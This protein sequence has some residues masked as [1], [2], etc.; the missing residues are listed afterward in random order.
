MNKV[1]KT[2]E[3]DKIKE[4]PDDKKE[5]NNVSLDE[6]MNKY[7][8]DEESY[9][10]LD[11][12]EDYKDEQEPEGNN[13][14]KNT[15]NDEEDL[16][17][18][19]VIS[20]IKDFDNNVFKYE[21]L[22][23]QDNYIIDEIKS[24]NAQKNY[25]MNSLQE[26]FLKVLQQFSFEE[27]NQCLFYSEVFIYLLKKTFFML[28]N[29]GPNDELINIFNI[30]QRFAAQIISK[31]NK[32]LN[33]KNKLSISEEDINSLCSITL[34]QIDF[35]IELYYIFITIR[36]LPQPDEFIDNSLEYLIKLY[37]LKNGTNKNLNEIDIVYI[38]KYIETIHQSIKNR[39]KL[40]ICLSLEQYK[41]IYTLG[42]LLL[43]DHRQLNIYYF[44][45]EMLCDIIELVD[46]N[47]YI[48][49]FLTEYLLCFNC[50]IEEYNLV[51]EKFKNYKFSKNIYSSYLNYFG[52]Y[53]LINSEDISLL[54]YF[55]MKV[56]CYLYLKNINYFTKF[57]E[58]ILQKIY[59]HNNQSFLL[60][61]LFIFKDFT[62]MKYDIEFSI[63][64]NIITHIYLSIASL[65]SSSDTNLVC[66]KFLVI[67]LKFFMNDLLKDLKSLRNSYLCFGKQN[68]ELKNILHINDTHETNKKKIKNKKNK[69]KDKKNNNDLDIE[70]EPK[71][72]IKCNCFSCCFSS[73][74]K[75]KSFKCGKCDINTNLRLQLI[76]PNKDDDL[77][78]C[79][80]CNINDYFKSFSNIFENEDKLELVKT[81]D[82]IFAQYSKYSKSFK[83]KENKKKKNDSNDDDEKM[84]DILTKTE[85]ENLNKDDNNFNKDNELFDKCVFY[86]EMMYKK[87]FLFLKLNLLNF[88]YISNQIQTQEKNENIYLS[89][90]VFLRSLL[91]EDK[92]KDKNYISFI[93]NLEQFFKVQKE[94]VFNLH[95]D[96]NIDEKTIQYF[97][98]FH[99]Y[100]NFL[101]NGHWKILEILI[102]D[103]S[104]FWQI[105]YQCMKILEKFI[106]ID[107]EAN[108]FQNLSVSIVGPLL[109]D[110]SLNI[111]EYSFELLFKL[112]QKKKIK[113]TD[114]IYILY[115]NINES[116][117][118]IRKRAI[119]ALS[120]LVFYEKER[121]SLK[122]IILIFLNKIYDNS[123]SDK[124]KSI[125]YDFF[126]QLFK[127]N[128]S[129][130]NEL[131][132]YF[133]NIIIELFSGSEEISGNYSNYLSTQL[134]LLFEK[135]YD[136]INTYD[137][138]IDYLMQN[139]IINKD[140]SNN[141][142]NNEN[143]EN[144]NEELSLTQRMEFIHALNFVQILTK[145]YKK[146]ISIYIEYFCS[147]LEYNGD[148]VLHNNRIIQLSCMII[149]NYFEEKKSGDND[150]SNIIEDEDT[151]TIKY[152]T[153]CK[154]ENL[155]LNIIMN[156]APVITFSALETYFKMIKNGVID[157]DKIEKFALM[158]FTFLKKLKEDEKKILNTQENIISKSL[159]I[160]SYI[161]YSLNDSEILNTFKDIYQT[162]DI[163]KEVIFDL[164]SF[165]Y[166]FRYNIPLQ[167]TKRI[168]EQN[169]YLINL[170]NSLSTKA[171]QSFTYFW[172]RFP[173][174]LLKSDKIIQTTFDNLENAD[175]KIIVLQSFNRLFKDMSI[176]C[177]ESRINKD[178]SF[179]FGIVHLFFENFIEKI[180]LFLVEENCDIVRLEAIHLIKLIID[181][182]NLNVHKI[183]PYAFASLFDCINEIRC[184]AVEI[185]QKGFS[186]SK[187]KSLNALGE[188]LKQAFNFQKKKYGSSKLINSFVKII[189]PETK[190]YKSSN[191]NIFELLFYKINKNKIKFQKKILEK[192]LSCIQEISN[193][194]N[195]LN[196]SSSSNAELKKCLNSFE[197]YEFIAKLIGDFKFQNSDEVYLVYD[198]LY[199]EYE[200]N[201]C[202]FKAK[203]K[204]YKEDESVQKMDMKLIN[205][206]LKS[207]LYLFLLR[208]LFIKYQIFSE[209]QLNDINNEGWKKFLEK[210]INIDNKKIKLPKKLESR[211]SKFKFIEF[212][213]NFEILNIQLFDNQL[214]SYNKF[215]KENK[216]NIN[217]CLGRMKSFSN[218]DINKFIGLYNGKKRSLADLSFKIL[219]DDN[220][221]GVEK[222]KRKTMF[223]TD[224]KVRNRISMNDNNESSENKNNDKV[225]EE[226][227]EEKEES[228]KKKRNVK[229]K[230][231]IPKSE[232]KKAKK[233]VKHR[234]SVVV[235]EEKDEMDD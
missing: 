108:I 160:F 235:I 29:T 189:D 86:Q 75:M 215:N 159:T 54:S 97:Y 51:Q 127:N 200:N 229:K 226:E 42:F 16:D 161:I 50:F 218:L 28:K 221:K 175:E 15:L 106:D 83:K 151:F 114:L 148:I 60:Y 67:V 212:Y 74:D 125:I 230:V 139:Y 141:S 207:G 26:L 88:I 111:R 8:S 36:Y 133:L 46:D 110:S 12:E 55:L 214:K 203:F 13:I 3:V 196:I 146:S 120:N 79:G 23:F 37:N 186:I 131:L 156:K 152:K 33:M 158:N 65:L 144:L 155:L 231:K 118:I 94:R 24:F 63:S 9:K 170:A 198:K 174:Y 185:I 162:I 202:V 187:D 142:Q 78:I 216:T 22:A 4:D 227:K 45:I 20:K 34:Q 154:I 19:S 206:Y 89:F 223:S 176:K 128:L 95:Q 77:T 224:I 117:F 213:S 163:I 204:Q 84:D 135:I 190:E 192:Y 101:F 171:F 137:I 57:I 188:G 150:N 100:I 199:M 58:D 59:S 184:V 49:K 232:V 96:I 145:Y 167:K 124:I 121:D 195:S 72:E 92:L 10:K 64:I 173:Y 209:D 47:H 44:I 166:L 126:V 30:I 21:H 153:L 11:E 220:N 93:E 217:I 228:K 85:E 18:G 104:Q 80:F 115:N 14:N 81:N 43:R 193:M 138:V 31:N 98:F 134:N 129:T 90:K 112:Y 172:V 123:E 116:S 208:F 53:K 165:Y 69:K 210:N 194:E 119:K 32:Y 61:I 234:K 39:K 91:Q 191:E 140:K 180:N 73:I 182:G 27:F 113:R 38:K 1:L 35:V 2:D 66:K 178:N 225:K 157:V 76:D 87:V 107:K 149:G 164:F 197:Y 205:N 52:Q 181:L 99:F 6:S 17:I 177:E 68:D 233:K 109:C 222:L 40:Q 168:T 147:L 132:Y 7:D 41:N 102:S 25:K 103:K 82:N 105:K 179:D 70:L 130:N 211:I 122:S 48:D 219:F 169:I 71:P 62:K 56:S 143:N 183:I 5:E 136:K 201:I